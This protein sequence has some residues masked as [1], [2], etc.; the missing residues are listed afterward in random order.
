MTSSGRD[1]HE[2]LE[3]LRR[4]R[5]ELSTRVDA[6]AGLLAE[7]EPSSREQQPRSP[8]ELLSELAAARSDHS[9]TAGAVGGRCVINT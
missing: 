3:E 7:L 2:V 6:V 1:E 4:A 8:L 5:P 9:V